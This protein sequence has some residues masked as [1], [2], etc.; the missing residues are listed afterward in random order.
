MLRVSAHA[1]VL[2]AHP[3]SARVVLGDDGDV[4]DAWLA[5]QSVLDRVL[6]DRLQAQERNGDGQHLWGDAHIH[7]QAVAETGAL[8]REVP[9]DRAE[10]L[11]QGRELRRAPAASSE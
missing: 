6:H 7:L 4:A 3:A 2:D 8:E 10:L 9:V 5:F 1:V 11:G